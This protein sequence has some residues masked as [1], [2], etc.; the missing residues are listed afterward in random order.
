MS[1]SAALNVSK[2]I[3][4]PFHC[5]LLCPAELQK[6]FEAIL[7]GD[8]T[9]APGEEDLAALTAGD[10]TP[11]AIARRKFFSA[12]VNKTSLQ[13]IERSAFITIL[14]NEEVSYDPAGFFEYF[15]F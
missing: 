11:W 3:I 5:R 12:G 6:A 8:F 4:S 10:R 14:D 13:A 15:F 1:F 2:C 7:N 9:P